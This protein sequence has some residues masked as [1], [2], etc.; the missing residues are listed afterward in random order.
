[1]TTVLLT[2]LLWV[3]IGRF[4]R[5]E[6]QVVQDDQETT[7]DIFKKIRFLKFNQTAFLVIILSFLIPSGVKVKS[8]IDD[9]WGMPKLD[10]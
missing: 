1:M 2:I 10:V 7:F 3:M 6:V 5:I 9:Q 4:K 8:A